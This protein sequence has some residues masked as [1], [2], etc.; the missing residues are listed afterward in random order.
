M[1]YSGR[2]S[3]A[4]ANAYAGSLLATG[5]FSSWEQVVAST[6]MREFMETLSQ[7]MPGSQGESLSLA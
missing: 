7:E 3:S 4:V 6:D 2:A 1:T 5:Q